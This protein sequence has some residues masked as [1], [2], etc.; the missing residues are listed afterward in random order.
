MADWFTEMV[1]KVSDEVIRSPEAAAKLALTDRVTSEDLKTALVNSENE[2][3]TQFA[4]NVR[5]IQEI[6][7][8]IQRTEEAALSREI[9]A[10]LNAR[11]RARE[12]EAGTAIRS[13]RV[14]WLRQR[15]HIGGGIDESSDTVQEAQ[16]AVDAAQKTYDAAKEKIDQSEAIRKLEAT[17]AQRHRELR[18]LLYPALMLRVN[19]VID[20]VLEASYE[21]DF[22]YAG[23]AVLTDPLE[24]SVE[25]VHTDASERIKYLI[26]KVGSGAIGVAGPRGSGKT[27]VLNQF[28]GTIKKDD[29]PQ[30]WGVCVPAPTKYD[31]RDF[32]L[33]LFA[34]LCIQVLGRSQARY[35]ESQLTRTKP[36]AKK[37]LPLF[38]LLAFGGAAALAC[39]GIVIGLRTARLGE[40]PHRM[41]DLLIACCCAIVFLWGAVTLGAI[42]LFIDEFTTPQERA[43]RSLGLVD[44]G[45]ASYR[46]LVSA[47]RPLAQLILVV[48]CLAGLV[49]ATLFAL[50]LVGDAPDPGYLAAGGLGIAAVIG[51][52][53]SVFMPR[54][55]PAERTYDDYRFGDSP[56]LVEARDWYAKVKF[57]QS[58]TTGWS[59][60][61]TLGNS[62]LPVQAQG[63]S[64]GSI[65]VT[66]LA[67]SNP[68]IIGAINTF[69]QS[70][71]ACNIH[72]PDEYPYIE[73]ASDG[74]EELVPVV[75]GL[76]E[77]DKIED[78]LDAQAFL[79]QIKAL[80][81][82]SSCLFLVSI[83]D[84]AMA[85]FERRGMPF[86]D[87]FDSSLSTVVTL[88]YLS[89]T[90]ART[91]T[92]SRLVGV[93][94][95]VA[96][97]LFVLAGGLARDLVRLIRQAVEAKERIEAEE[98]GNIT[99]QLDGLA[100]A[101]IT[102]E[103]DA[104]KKAV[105]ARA[106]TLAPCPA[107]ERLL[108][109]AGERQPETADAEEYF[110][111]LLNQAVSLIDSV[112]DGTANQTDRPEEAA[113]AG[114]NPAREIG[115]FIYWLATVGQVFLACSSR[116]DF[117]DGENADNDKSFERLAQAKQNFPI[118]PDYV[119]S[120]TKAVRT[121][122]RLPAMQPA[123]KTLV[124]V[125]PVAQ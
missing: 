102:T 11:R 65:A 81:S 94:E 13:S 67:M 77:I 120:A 108:T 21:R 74:S 24:V 107:K 116:Q 9:Q 70:L 109:W 20:D 32:L 122:W 123:D 5:A 29:K 96:D 112:C 100:L 115:V 25:P 83:S 51:L 85:A 118:G 28:A 49:S 92:G 56:Y 125:P 44:D 80:F 30:Q 79:N 23:R 58:F 89:R 31:S 99:L 86:R 15:L 17:T 3:R 105:L 18:R 95:P 84:D 91:L 7:D 37:I 57:Q 53:I 36:P 54:L 119:L 69:T 4:D 87:A 66:P 117:Q 19:Q 97:L 72:G 35:L 71:A 113:D 33:Y 39:F 114:S 34:Q 78:P 64:S 22:S 27:T 110:A 106:R 124:V 82:G 50:L 43:P 101:L 76:D 6:R 61:V 59:G 104:K 8:D 10:V 73:H 26:E 103:I 98:Q 90:E 45:L 1:E 46:K 40:S 42:Y 63:G 14:R 121:A 2:L 41:T 75:I 111:Q 88:S 47:I 38:W 62:S 55:L 16:N 52:W 93:Q 68:E 60:T 12:A 48:S